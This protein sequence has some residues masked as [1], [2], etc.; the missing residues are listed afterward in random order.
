MRSLITPAPSIFDSSP[1]DVAEK[2]L[3]DRFVKTVGMHAVPP[4]ITGTFMP[5]SNN[6][7]I[8]DTQFTY[9]SKSTNNFETN[10]ISNDFVSCDNNCDFYENQLRLNNAPVW[11]NVENI[12]SFVPRPAF[13]P[14]GSRNRPTFVPASRPFL[15]GWHNPAARPMTRPKSH[16]FQQ[17]SRPGSYNQMDIDGRWGTTIKKTAACCSWQRKYKPY[18]IRITRTHGNLNNLQY[19]PSTKKEIGGTV[20]FGF[21]DVKD[22]RKKAPLGLPTSFED[23]YMWKELQNL[24]WFQL[25]DSSHVILRVQGD[26][27]IYCFKLTDIHQT[28]KSSVCWQKQP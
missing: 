16:Y 27:I 11:K 17:F 24:N 5:P 26:S 28:E 18:S 8:D 7:D 13:V 1:K 15:A 3:H 14:A 21:G 22:H 23:V 4:P 2:P 9:G 19:N 25:P 6:P 10:S 20:T 12:P